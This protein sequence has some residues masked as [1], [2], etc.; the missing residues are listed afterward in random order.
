MSDRPFPR[1]IENI[2]IREPGIVR[3][4]KRLAEVGPASLETDYCQEADLIIAAGSECHLAKRSPMQR[5]TTRHI[6][7]NA[8]VA[9]W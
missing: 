3:G 6:E 8:L 9:A 4:S 2:V 5:T 7:S 1:E